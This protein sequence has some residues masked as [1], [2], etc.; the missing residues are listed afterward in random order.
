VPSGTGAAAARRDARCTTLKGEIRMA[1]K[2]AKKP[3]AKKA[4]K[5]TAKKR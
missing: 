2:T 5:K 4:T 1:K 3:A